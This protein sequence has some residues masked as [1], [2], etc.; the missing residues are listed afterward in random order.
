MDL[1]LFLI[2]DAQDYINFTMVVRAVTSS[3]IL[4]ESFERQAHMNHS[5]MGDRP[6]RMASSF[7]MMNTG[8]K[9]GLKA[10]K[11]AK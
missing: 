8:K 1:L 7:G 9:N 6:S 2:K 5:I 3:S 11:W 4:K 10:T